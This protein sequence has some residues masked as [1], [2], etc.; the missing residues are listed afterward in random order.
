[1]CDLYDKYYQVLDELADEIKNLSLTSQDIIIV[2]GNNKD[3][4]SINNYYNNCNKLGKD[5]YEKNAIIFDKNTAIIDNISLYELWN[6]NITD[7]TREQIWKY[8]FTLYLYSYSIIKKVNIGDLL[9]KFKGINFDELENKDIFIYSI[10]DNLNST[11]RINKLI[12]NETKKLNNKP[13]TNPLLDNL[14]NLANLNLGEGLINGEIGKLAKEI[15]GE[16]N[17]ETFQKDLEDKDPQE[18]LNSLFTGNLDSNSPIMGLVNT[19][20]GKIQDKISKGSINENTLFNE[21]QNILGGTNKMSGTSKKNLN[22][23]K[24]KVK[25]KIRQR[26]NCNN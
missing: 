21:A 16:I 14:G 7:L 25:N 4:D 19:I 17:P 6:S 12:R 3:K 18:L 8:L 13:N 24:N 1:M 10:I 2:S 22:Q 11:K 20:S 9:K 23:R 15:A 5:F 26:Q